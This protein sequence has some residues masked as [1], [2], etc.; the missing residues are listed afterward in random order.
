MLYILDTDHMTLWQ[1]GN[2]GIVDNLRRVPITDR[3]VTQIS[4]TEQI[5]GWQAM[6]TRARNEQEIARNLQRLYKT[7]AFYHSLQVLPYDSDAIRLFEQFRK[8]KIRIGSQD[9][10]ISSIAAS[11]NA[12]VVTRNLRD[13]RQIP[14]LQVVDWSGAPARSS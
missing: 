4:L 13:F 6:I 3:A 14:D 10:R 8:A 2:Q 1:H 5:Q 11:K 7:I 12:T 9:L